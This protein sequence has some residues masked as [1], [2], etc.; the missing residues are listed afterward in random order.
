[1]NRLVPLVAVLVMACAP[2]AP[3]TSPDIK[4]PARMDVLVSVGN[5][6]VDPAIAQVKEGGN[7][8]WTND[9]DYLAVLS[10]PGADAAHFECKELR[11]NFVRNG[12]TLE[13]LP[14]QAGAVRVTLPC[15]LKKGQYPY[16]VKLVRDFSQMENP[17]FTLSAQLVVQ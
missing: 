6:S 12:N 7:V 8:A 4:E 15:A 9:S 11:P 17:L 3:F 13:S 10:F 16:I 1:M 14:F 2:Q 5:S